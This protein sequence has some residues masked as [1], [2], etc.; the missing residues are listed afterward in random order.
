MFFF[1]KSKSGKTKLRYNGQAMKQIVFQ[2]K[3]SISLRKAE[4]F[5]NKLSKDYSDGGVQGSLIISTFISGLGW[6]SA[7]NHEVGEEIDLF[8]D[9]QDQYIDQGKMKTK[10]ISIWVIN[11]KKGRARGGN[12][13]N[14]D[15]LFVALKHAIGKSM[16]REI[17]TP[18]KLKSFLGLKRTDKVPMSKIP[19]IDEVLGSNRSLNVM[20]AFSYFSSKSTPIQINLKLYNEHYRLVANDKRNKALIYGEPIPKSS[21]YSFSVKKEHVILFNGEQTELSLDEWKLKKKEKII[22]LC[23]KDDAKLKETRD[24]FIFEA[25]ELIKITKGFINLYKFKKVKYASLEY[26]RQMSKTIRE[27]LEITPVEAELLNNAFSGG[28]QYIETGYKGYGQ[29]FDINSMY[30]SCLRHAHF[31]I[32]VAPGEPLTLTKE[33]F[34]KQTYFKYGIYRCKVIGSSKLFTPRRNNYYTHYDLKLAKQLGLKL[35]IIEDGQMNF[36]Y[37]ARDKLVSSSRVFKE[38]VEF[39]F[40]IKKKHALGLSKLMLNMLWGALSEKMDFHADFNKHA[41]DEIPSEWRIRSISNIGGDKIRVGYDK[42]QCQYRTNFG[43]LGCFLTSFAREQFGTRI[44]PYADKIV[45]IHTDSFTVREHV[46][47]DGVGDNFNCFKVEY[48]GQVELEKINAKYKVG[49]NRGTHAP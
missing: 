33:E 5:I 3:K 1:N 32:P 36:Y 25:D 42:Y 18:E 12:D 22:A 10:L 40:D 27:P 20:G 45:R 17:K 4:K 8:P 28:L 7:G 11:A 26:F 35:E 9:Y 37:Y 21:V 43:R 41:D 38:Y 19:L 39:F 29:T 2:S 47:V 44:Q 31:M 13:E 16:P 24:K 23:S 6:R 34:N 46:N 48:E 14:N 30:P 49:V 15:C